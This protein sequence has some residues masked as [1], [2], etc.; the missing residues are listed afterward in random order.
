MAKA[1]FGAIVTDVRGKLGGHVFQGNGF[2]T[3]VRTH[4]PGKGGMR[5]RSDFF[6]NKIPEIQQAWKDESESIKTEWANLARSN[7]ILGTFN[8]WIF[9]TGQNMY[10]RHYS[11]YYA[12]G[13]TGTIDVA[14]A[15]NDLPSSNLQHVEFNFSTQEIDVQFAFDRFSDAV[16]VY[17]R[18]VNKFGLS[19]NADK[20]PWLYG[21][22]DETP[23]DDLLWD[24]FFAKYPDVQ[25]GDPVQFG[26]KQV[27]QYGFESFVKTVYGTYV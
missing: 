1:K 8:N 24:A 9:L 6:K 25:E 18:P 17:A 27:N 19:I 7:P 15:V 23:Q 12:S 21:E 26:I 13:F 5:F 11:A 20:L 14:N 22:V 10:L 3:S 2:T 16:A 4:N